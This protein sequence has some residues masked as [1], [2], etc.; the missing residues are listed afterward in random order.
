MT[1]PISIV[2]PNYNGAPYVRETIESLLGQT[3]GD[4]KLTFLD[5]Q[6]TDE[7]LEIAESFRDPRYSVVRSSE[8]VTMAGNWNR[9][10]ALA[11]APYFL[12]AHNDDVYEP[13]FLEVMLPLIEGSPRAFMAHCKVQN[14]DDDGKPIYTPQQ[15]YKDSLWPTED[16]CERPVKEELAW[17][18][19]G[20]IVIAP[21]AVFRTEAFRA[22]GPF[23]ERYQMVTDWEY[24]LRGLLHGYTMVCTHRRLMRWRRHARTATRAMEASMRR[25]H[26]EI[27]VCEWVAAEAYRLHL[28]DGPEPDYRIVLNTM[29]TEF[30]GRLERSDR[31]G[32]RA[33]YD[34]AL[35]RVPAFRR[36]P[37]RLVMQFGL[38]SGRPGGRA[39]KWAETAYLDF[40]SAGRRAPSDGRPSSR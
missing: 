2:I 3:F 16:P 22:I 4:F 17:M 21:T 8:R 39:L 28:A 30:A 6:S 37:H 35:S 32:A 26:E 25:F 7:S 12:L 10:A 15:A 29:L 31:A 23:D 1:H 13:E 19:R 9:A 20:D 34:L 36:S 38:A 18:R 24:W 27:D 5:D 14:I 11:D 40:V 33:I